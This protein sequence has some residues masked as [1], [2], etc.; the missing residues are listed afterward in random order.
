MSNI[1]SYGIK[2]IESSLISKLDYYIN[3]VLRAIGE[4]DNDITWYICEECD[5]PTHLIPPFIER[6]TRIA[7]ISFINSKFGCCDYRTKEVWISTHALLTALSPSWDRMMQ[8]VNFSS[9]H[10]F[11]SGSNKRQV[12]P[13]LI[14]VIIDELTHIKTRADHGEPAYEEQFNKYWQKYFYGRFR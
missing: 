11:R 8:A 3:K 13:I 4:N 14:Q 12:P 7:N 5:L 2:T 1:K 6:I 9:L 10:Q